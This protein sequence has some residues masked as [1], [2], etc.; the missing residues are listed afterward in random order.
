MQHEPP[1]H[2]SSVSSQCPE[3]PSS[4]LWD[5][6]VTAILT[7]DHNGHIRDANAAA[8]LLLAGSSRRLHG[9]PLE[10]LLR[11]SS[12]DFELL[13]QAFKNQQSVSDSDVTWVLHNGTQMTLELVV[14]PCDLWA[15]N[16][17]S[18]NSNQGSNGQR[19]PGQLLELRQVD[20]IR[21]LNQEQTQQH[22]LAAAQQLVRGLAHEIK[23]PLGGIRGAAQ[24]LDAKLGDAQL[25]EYTQLI[26]KQ[27]DRLRLMVD[28]LLGP[29]K[30]GQRAA[31]N[32]HQLIE[33]SLQ[34]VT[35]NQRHAIAIHKDYDPS[36][37][38]IVIV[39]HQIEQ[40]VLNILQN[41]VQALHSVSRTLSDPRLVVKTRVVHQETIYGKRYRQCLLISILDNGPGVDTELKDTLFYP[42][43]SGHD[44]GTGLGLS[45]AQSL[46]H[47]HAGKIELNSRP[48]HT[49][50]TLYLPYSNDTTEADTDSSKVGLA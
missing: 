14:S 31:V 16:A 6:L 2:S 11:Y 45:I 23:N 1:D 44:S 47:Q 15:S 27:A 35:L 18:S 5:Q 40:V 41:A 30:P 34:V 29:N 24:L 19:Q 42:L 32:V 22:Q 37:P 48:G 4:Y 8:E 36:L 39:E 26:I 13:H 49:E 50:F 7:L 10:S 21:R 25:Q 28:K 33:R 12:I 43:V 17:V 46:V 38:D 9:A 20:L 3:Q